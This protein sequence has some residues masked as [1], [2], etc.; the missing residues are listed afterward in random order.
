MADLSETAVVLPQQPSQVELT[1]FLN[2]MG[3]LGALTFQPVNRVTVL[4]P[5]ELLPLPD[6]DFLVIGTLAHLG[7]GSDLLARSPYRV[8]GDSLQVLLPTP[9]ENIWHLFGDR[10]GDARRGAATALTTPFGEGAA[11]M[12]GAQSPGG[13]QRSVVAL[14]AGSPQGLEA[15]VNAMRNARLCRT[16]RVTWL[17]WQLEPS[18]HTV[19]AAPI[20]SA[21]P[22]GCGPNGGCRTNQ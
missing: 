18:R 14:L 22:T 3:N 21:S 16:Y 15:M 17:C 9:L 12:I 2:M 8:D 7:A 4:R 1:A 5:N 19:A 11:A 6:K 10:T 20:R 13:P